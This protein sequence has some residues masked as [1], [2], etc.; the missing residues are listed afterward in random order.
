MT[1]S[2]QSTRDALAGVL[3]W[4]KP[5]SSDPYWAKVGPSPKVRHCD[6]HPIGD[7][8][9]AISALW[10]EH[11]AGWEWTIEPDY[12]ASCRDTRGEVWAAQRRGSMTTEVSV[13]RT[14]DELADRLALLLA[15]LKVEKK[16]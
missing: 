6:D 5:T 11:L 12:E 1:P 10:R 8:L 14:N 3:G 4:S 7:S 15:A 16:G 2:N 9:D 13:P